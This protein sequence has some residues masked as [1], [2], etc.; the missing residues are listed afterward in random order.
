MK[1]SPFRKD[2]LVAWCI[3]PF[4]VKKRNPEERAAMLKKLG[5]TRLAYDWRKQHIPEFDRELDALQSNGIDLEAFWL[6]CK[7]ELT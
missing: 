1:S 3:V 4:D 2:N 7:I 6:P 5:I